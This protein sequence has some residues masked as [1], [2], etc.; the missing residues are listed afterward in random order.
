MTLGH[1]TDLHKRLNRYIEKYVSTP[2]QPPAADNMRYA[3]LTLNISFKKVYKHLTALVGLTDNQATY[4]YFM[5]VHIRA[6]STVVD[7]SKLSLSDASSD[8]ANKHGKDGRSKNVSEHAGSTSNKR[9]K[10]ERYVPDL[11]L[12]DIEAN[13]EFQ[14]SAQSDILNEQTNR[15]LDI[16]GASSDDDYLPPHNVTKLLARQPIKERPHR[17]RKAKIDKKVYDKG[18]PSSAEYIDLSTISLPDASPNKAN[19]H[20]EDSRSKKEPVHAD[21]T[22]NE[23]NKVIQ[24]FE[25]SSQS[26]GL[27]EQTNQS[28]DITGATSDDDYLPPY[29]V[30]KLLARQSVKERPHLERKARSDSNPT[31]QLHGRG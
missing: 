27:N 1:W 11:G 19:T 2:E 20:S 26:H 7:L 24:E 16:T 21:S 18:G 5:C 23:N 13:Q 25:T 9:N 14:T 29:N 8:K 28:L 17:E 31:S 12:K 30:T 15:S 22:S 3:Q 10:V 6:E 4:P